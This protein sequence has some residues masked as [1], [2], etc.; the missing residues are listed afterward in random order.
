MFV[1]L[2]DLIYHVNPFFGPFPSDCHITI[3]RG[4]SGSGLH[5]SIKLVSSIDV[6][7]LELSQCYWMNA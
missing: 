3:K 7:G 1:P 2:N 4:R 5:F 6:E